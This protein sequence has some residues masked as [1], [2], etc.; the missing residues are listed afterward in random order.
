[1]MLDIESFRRLG[2]NQ[3]VEFKASFADQDEIIDTLVAFANAQGGRVFVGFSPDVGHDLRGLNVGRNTLEQF[4]V[5]LR[6]RAGILPAFQPTIVEYEG[7]KF[8]VLSVEEHKPGQLFLSDGRAWI[9][10]VSTNQKMTANQIRLRILEDPE[11]AVGR[12]LF[13]AIGGASRHAKDESQFTFTRN[14]ELVQGEYV[15]SIECRFVGPLVNPPM[16]WQRVRVERSQPRHQ[17]EY[18]TI[19]SGALRRSETRVF[20]I[21]T[22]A[23]N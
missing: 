22:S 12:P 10:V 20:Q 14:L 15:E 11:L 18:P 17:P 23:S 19:S 6:D 2:E 8:A 21:S 3:Q 7:K 9:R 1:M 16:N 4:A 13:Q 5:L